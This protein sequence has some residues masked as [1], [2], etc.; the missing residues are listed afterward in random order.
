MYLIPTALV[1]IIP[2]KQ[3]DHKKLEEIGYKF[4][5][6]EKHHKVYKHTVIKPPHKGATY[7]VSNGSKT[8]HFN[9]FY[10]QIKATV[11]LSMDAMA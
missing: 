8:Q 4:S 3:K 11:K 7:R 9:E 1:L 5:H 10:A 2:L 6:N